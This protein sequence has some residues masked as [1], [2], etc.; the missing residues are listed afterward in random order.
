M[1]QGVDLLPSW[2]DPGR[3]VRD[4]VLVENRHNPTTVHLRTYV[5]DRYKLTVYRRSD[6]GELFDLRE[7]PGERRNLW[8]EPGAAELKARLLLRLAQ[9][10]FQRE[11][12]PMP[13]IAGA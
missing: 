8:S 5:E 6:E 12:T 3:A 10:D 4:H 11:A 13:R 7:D 1:M 2:R 9:A